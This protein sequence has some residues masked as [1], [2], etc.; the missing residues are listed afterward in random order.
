MGGGG[1][2][3]P[4]EIRY[5]FYPFAFRPALGKE[6]AALV[7]LPLS[8]E[9][10]V[11]LFHGPG[12]RLAQDLR[13]DRFAQEIV[14]PLF[15]SLDDRFE[16]RGFGKQREGDERVFSKGLLQKREAGAF[17]DD[18]IGQDD[19]VP[20]EAGKRFRGCFEIGYGCDGIFR[21]GQRPG[22]KFK[23][24]RVIVNEQDAKG[25][26]DATILSQDPESSDRGRSLVAVQGLEPRTL[27]I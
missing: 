6:L 3:K 9:D 24:F 16:R 10:E 20:L 4:L 25:R 27:R 2:K 22:G 26:H 15:Q 1:D 23:E 12:N 14:G 8:L 11:D 13:G 21:A 5:L 7:L 18:Q 19:G 17:P